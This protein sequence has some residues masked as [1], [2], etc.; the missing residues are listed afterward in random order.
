MDKKE[1][2]NKMIE[3]LIHTM[4]QIHE[5]TQMIYPIFPY[6]LIIS[7]IIFIFLYTYHSLYRVNRNLFLNKAAE[8]NLDKNRKIPKIVFY[9]VSTFV[10]IMTF[11]IYHKIKDMIIEDLPMKPVSLFFLVLCPCIFILAIVGFFMF[12]SNIITFAEA[13]DMKNGIVACVIFIYISLFMIYLSNNNKIEYNEAFMYLCGF[14]VVFLI[15]HFLYLVS[16]AN[17]L[18]V[19]MENEKLDILSKICLLGKKGTIET[20]PYIKKV[21]NESFRNLVENYETLYEKFNIKDDEVEHFDLLGTSN[22][23]TSGMDQMDNSIEDIPKDKY[24]ENVIK[25]NTISEEEDDDQENLKYEFGIPIQYYNNNTKQYEDLC[26]RDFYY[27][28]SYYSYLAGSPENG[29]PDLNALKG[30]VRD[31]KCRI[32]HLDIYSSLPNNIGS[33]VAK[34]VVRCE[35]MNSKAKAIP[36]EDCLNVISKYVWNDGS[37]SLPLFLYLRFNVDN[38]KHIYQKTYQYIDEYFGNYL[39]DK[40]HGFNERNHLFPISKLPIKD[41]LGKVVLLTNVYP[42]YTVLDEIINCNVE[43]KLSSIKMKEF[44]KEYV[45][46]DKQGL[47]ID[48]TKNDIIKDNRM[49]INFFYTNPNS[50]YNKE[51]AKLQSK[52]GLFNPN[53]NEVAKYGGQSGLVYVYVPDKNME[54]ILNYF[55]SYKKQL[56]LKKPFLRFIAKEEEEKPDTVTDDLTPPTETQSAMKELISYNPTFG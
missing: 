19:Q 21:E 56:I 38:N 32:I 13:K 53:F 10:I 6:V 22:K 27:M 52:A 34:P 33:S 4:N 9:S 30:V 37:Q 3:L 17:S 46:Y 36:L 50:S 42:T 16:S 2:Y 43:D 39:V 15:I 49:N 7:T 31:F 20:K 44:K 47:L 48:Y 14:M 28:G 45:T 26:I 51:D 12:Q 54:T 5:F 23:S 55:N 35:N 41:A 40:L 18:T 11:Y 29:T 8:H 24:I 25:P 1:G